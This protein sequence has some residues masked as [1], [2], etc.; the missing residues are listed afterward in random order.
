MN[1]L[2]QFRAHVYELSERM[3][4]LGVSADLWMMSLSELEGVY[5]MLQRRLV[6]VSDSSQAKHA[7]GAQ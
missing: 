4:S 6:T 2:E 7:Q 1:T 3:P 5:R